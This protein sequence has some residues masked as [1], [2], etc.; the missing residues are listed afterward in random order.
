MAAD[1]AS[2]SSRV[3]HLV[4]MASGGGWTQAEEME[5]FVKQE[6]GT[7]GMSSVAELQAKF[8]EIK[9]RPDS[10]EV[11]AGHP[12]RMWSSYLWFRPMDGLLPLSIPM[13]LAQGTADK[14]VPVESARALRDQFARLG[15]TNLTYVEYPGLDHHFSNA[16]G[17]SH[18]IDL[19]GDAFSWMDKT[20][21]P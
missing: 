21:L 13:L 18:L 2:Q 20:G 14:A 6:P 4:M 7:L 9:A 3:T 10:D 5:H 19:Q 11:W 15:H 16:A 1:L 8:D 12:F 17:E